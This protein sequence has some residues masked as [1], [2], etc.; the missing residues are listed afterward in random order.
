MPRL[1]ADAQGINRMFKQ[2]AERLRAVGT[3]RILASQ[4]EQ[5]AVGAVEHLLDRL[6]GRGAGHAHNLPGANDKLSA[7][8]QLAN[9]ADVIVE[10]NGLR[11]LGTQVR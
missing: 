5:F 8:R 3:G 7:Y 10:I 11:G 2:G 9:R 1:V 4:L 6:I